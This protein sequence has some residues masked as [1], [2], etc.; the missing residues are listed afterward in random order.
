MTKQN[1][2]FRKPEKIED[3]LLAACR[4]MTQKGYAQLSMR[5]IAVEAGSH[6]SLL[7]HYFKNKDELFLE[8]FRFLNQRYVNI[9]E[10]VAILPEPIPKKLKTGFQEFQKFVEAEPKWILMIIDIT[11][12][13]VQKSESKKEVISLYSRLMDLITR[14][15]TEGRNNKEVEK[16]FDDQV[17]S[18]LILATLMGLG[19]FYVMDKKLVNFPKAYQYFLKMITQFT[20]EQ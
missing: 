12:Q 9:I 13:A 7:Y 8:L 15:F 11:V 5:D 14:T 2:T 6:K 4:V 3:F 19:V 16:K 10:E 17:I 20:I 18:S 1:K